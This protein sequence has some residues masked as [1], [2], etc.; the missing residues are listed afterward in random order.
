MMAIP[1][2]LVPS[3]PGRNLMRRVIREAWRALLA[4][5]PQA[6]R[7][8]SVRVTLHAMPQDPSAP[9]TAAG[10]R[11]LR[12]FAR[13]PTDGVLKRRIRVEIDGLLDRL[14]S[15]LA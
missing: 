1:K 7:G 6:L 5:R 11:A 4:R 14:S 9:K 15:R 3:S 2:K 12:P 13:R 8:A 10:G